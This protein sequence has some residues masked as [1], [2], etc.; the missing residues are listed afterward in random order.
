MDQY[1]AHTHT[2]I[3]IAE[4]KV[5]KWH[6]E[7]N[8]LACN[9][10]PNQ[11]HLWLFSS[12]A[13]HCY[14]ST[15]QMTTPVCL[16]CPLVLKETAKPCWQY[17]FIATLYDVAAITINEARKYIFYSSSYQLSKDTHLWICSQLW[18]SVRCMAIAFTF[19]SVFPSTTAVLHAQHPY[20][21]FFESE[22]NSPPPFSCEQ[23]RILWRYLSIAASPT[24][25]ANIL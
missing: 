18:S 1:I 14:D 6:L 22:C 4:K 11:Y 13:V 24:Y 15:L 21:T 5:E 16:L 9:L 17:S 25:A 19:Q 2:H 12:H 23:F 8:T 20:S 3:Y 10:P 7:F